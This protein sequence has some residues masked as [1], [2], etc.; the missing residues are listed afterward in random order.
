[1]PGVQ[2][3]QQI[4][5]FAAANLPEHYAVRAV[6]ESSLEEIADGD[7]RKAI[8]FAASLE[9]NEVFLRQLNL[10][11]VLDH[12]H[13]LVLGNKFSEDR[14]K[15]G[16][17]SPGSTA[18]EDVLA[19]KHV[20]FEVVCEGEV[21]SASPNQILHLEVAGVEL[22]DRER[23]AAKTARRDDRC[24]AAAIGQPRVEN[25]FRFGDVVTKTPG[26]VLHDNHERLFA[27]GHARHVLKEARLLDEHAVGA[28]HHYLA[29][30]IVE[31]EVLDGL[32]ERQDHFK[33]VHQS[34]PL[35]S[36]TKY[37]SLGS[38]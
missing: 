3:L 28:I 30:R 23:H 9:S 4:E 19:C 22:A 13:P 35:A 7:C 12:K 34:P 5:G 36:C 37:E 8:L 29:D 27:D 24:D 18:D 14:Q 10:G 20:V 33:S 31:N 11:S 15:C 2:E 6:A 16:F 38:L 21:E 17:T 26:D 1:M 32:Q 25:G